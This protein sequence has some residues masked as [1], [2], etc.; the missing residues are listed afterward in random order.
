MGKN[1]VPETNLAAGGLK[2]VQIYLKL[3]DI[4]VNYGPHL[5]SVDVQAQRKRSCVLSMCSTPMQDYENEK[6]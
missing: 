1:Q 2:P 4:S 5:V 6:Y 3:C